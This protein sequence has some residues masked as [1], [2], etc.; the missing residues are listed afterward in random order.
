MRSPFSPGPLSSVDDRKRPESM[1]S[2]ESEISGIL[3]ENIQAQAL[4]MEAQVALHIP[5]SGCKSGS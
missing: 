2:D 3:I 4:R 5:I 1:A